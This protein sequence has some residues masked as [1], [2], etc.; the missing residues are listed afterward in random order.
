MLNDLNL[1]QC[2]CPVFKLGCLDNLLSVST[3]MGPSGIV[4]EGSK[5]A[6]QCPPAES[7]I[8]GLKGKVEVE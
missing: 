1:P 5:G 3:G 7:G 2:P 8:P 6:G 4:A